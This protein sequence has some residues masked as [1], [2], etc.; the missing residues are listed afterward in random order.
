[1]V[2]FNNLPNK[3][4]SKKENNTITKDCK[5]LTLN[6]FKENVTK[7]LEKDVYIIVWCLIT[8]YYTIFNKLKLKEGYEQELQKFFFN[9]YEVSHT[10]YW[11]IAKEF[12]I[13]KP[14]VI[15]LLYNFALEFAMYFHI[16]KNSPKD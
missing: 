9:T 5:L 13:T 16:A 12:N 2:F 4:I 7:N 1:M 11:N 3:S 14:E 15:T 10:G 8:Q 6:I